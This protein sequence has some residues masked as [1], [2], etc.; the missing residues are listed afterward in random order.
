MTSQT[1]RESF[2]HFFILSKSPCKRDLVQY[3]E[4]NDTF[5]LPPP[6][7]STLHGVVRSGNLEAFE[8]MYKITYLYLKKKYAISIFILFSF[9]RCPNY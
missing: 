3:M 1:R 5:Q 4:R 9:F 8:V 6:D 2:V 7:L